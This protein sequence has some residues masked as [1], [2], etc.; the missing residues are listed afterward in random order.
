MIQETLQKRRR[1]RAMPCSFSDVFGCPVRCALCALRGECSPNSLCHAS[2]CLHNGVAD[3][4]MFFGL[5]S[6][7]AP[8]P[9]AIAREWSFLICLR[10]LRP[11]LKTVLRLSVSEVG[12]LMSLS[13]R[14]VELKCVEKRAPKAEDH[15]TTE[16]FPGNPRFFLLEVISPMPV[17]RPSSGRITCGCMSFSHGWSSKRQTGKRVSER[18]FHLRKSDESLYRHFLTT[19]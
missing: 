11:Q 14:K 12:T 1:V 2:G 13:H 18:R 9:S 15:R 5:R 16:Q 6:G 8:C 19:L 17:L 4:A 10:H 7:G 3:S